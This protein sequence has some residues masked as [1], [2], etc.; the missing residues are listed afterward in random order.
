[1]NRVKSLTVQ[2][3]LVMTRN[4]RF[5][6]AV[7]KML[8][9]SDPRVRDAC[10]RGEFWA[11][12]IER[13]FPR[14]LIQRQDIDVADY[15]L[16]AEELAAE[17]LGHD[18]P[19]YSMKLDSTT[20]A[21]VSD[22]VLI[23]TKKLL[24]PRYNSALGYMHIPIKGLTPLPGSR[25]Y[26]VTYRYSIDGTEMDGENIAYITSIDGDLNQLFNSMMN[27]LGQRIFEDIN[28]LIDDEDIMTG[29]SD[30]LD[31]SL[32]L[33]NRFLGGLPIAIAIN[34][35]ALGP[36][37]LIE[38]ISKMALDDSP[39]RVSDI[40]VSIGGSDNFVRFIIYQVTF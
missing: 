39:N 31:I 2:T 15:R 13:Q 34:N 28:S 26:V 11:A 37:I 21:N 23:D 7:A 33:I 12:L 18:V 10:D 24:P 29:I 30:E 5:A 6:Q 32:I 20:M 22:P 8:D 9:D 36:D 14:L 40:I 4:L 35:F 1:M 17:D 38:T 3:C 16:W 19:V 27:Q 25:G